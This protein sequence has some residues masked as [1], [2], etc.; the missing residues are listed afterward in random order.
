MNA[1]PWVLL[2]VFAALGLAYVTFFTEW[3][4]LAPIEI[5]SQLRFTIQPPRFGRPVKKPDPP[6]QPTPADRGGP[7]N[8]VERIGQPARGMI[9]QAP[10]GVANVTFSLDAWY[11]LTRIRVEDVPADGTPPKVLW[12]LTGTS[13]TVNSIL[14]GR[15]LEGMKPVPPVSSAEPLKAGVPYRL[16]LEAGRR[17][18]THNFRTMQ[19]PPTE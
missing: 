6:G 4:R 1:R 12:H 15:D 9:D 5:A 7:R 13:L 14:Y 17:R 11:N 10:G 3:L 18:G 19:P 16:I 2:G 8:D